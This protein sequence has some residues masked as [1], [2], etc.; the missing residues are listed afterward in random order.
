MITHTLNH[1][2]NCV[3]LNNHHG[4]FNELLGRFGDYGMQS[5]D[6]NILYLLATDAYFVLDKND[7]ILTNGRDNFFR[8]KLKRQ[9]DF[10]K[11]ESVLLINGDPS[12]TDEHITFVN[13]QNLDNASKF[14]NE[15]EKITK[16][17]VEGFVIGFNA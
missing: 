11:V 12:I 9:D 4:D 14:L 16:C 15:L 13:Q 8:Y 6:D 1:L 3:I 2:L 7:L 17:E 5:D 10:D